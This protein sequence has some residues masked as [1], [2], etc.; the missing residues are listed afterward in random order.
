[1]NTM[2][3]KYILFVI[4]TITFG[5]VA[6]SCGHDEDEDDIYQKENSTT[7]N[8][9]QQFVGKWICYND[10]YGDPWDEPLEFQF[11]DDGTGYQ[12][13]QE[14]PFSQRWDF[15][16]TVTSTKLVIKTKFGVYNLV[17]EISTKRQTLVLYGW[18]DDDME[19]LT[20]V[21]E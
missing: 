10:A 5:L 7:N 15:T 2:L 17:Y 18:D 12:W 11:Y 6:I 8:L 16:Y 20:F 9:Y 14:E 4:F 19:V 3:K 1:M 21:K 13:F